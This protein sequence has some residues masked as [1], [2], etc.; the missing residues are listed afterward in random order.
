MRAYRNESFSQLLTF[1]AAVA[2][3]GSFVVASGSEAEGAGRYAP[4]LV[5]LA[6]GA[7]CYLRLARAGV[8]ADDEGIRIVNPLRTV[9]VPWGRVVRFNVRRHGGF[10]A[11]GFAMLDDGTEIKVWG[12]QAR[13]GS[14]GAIR[15]A[16]RLADDLNE[17]LSQARAVAAERASA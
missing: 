10:P 11:V 8:Y 16:M 14:P 2:V 12:M 7:F 4:P 15:V 6:L 13:N 17:R 9:R 3:L 1:I 5:M